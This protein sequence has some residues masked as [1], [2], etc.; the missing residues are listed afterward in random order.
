VVGRRRWWNGR[1][2]TTH[3]GGSRL[4]TC[5]VWR[6]LQGREMGQLVAKHDHPGILYIRLFHHISALL[7]CR[8]RGY[9]YISPGC[10]TTNPQLSYFWFHLSGNPPFSIR[11]GTLV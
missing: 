8:R 11:W 1:R 3:G 5:F 7:S 6:I 10:L 4:S 9:L 2:T